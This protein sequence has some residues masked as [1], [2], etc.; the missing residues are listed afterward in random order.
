MIVSIPLSKNQISMVASK[1][2]GTA[3]ISCVFCD[4]RIGWLS[5]TEIEYMMNEFGL[6]ICDYCIEGY[7]RYIVEIRE[8]DWNHL[9]L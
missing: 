7:R 3:K 1:R 6:P 9:R 5:V 4:R 2:R 8:E